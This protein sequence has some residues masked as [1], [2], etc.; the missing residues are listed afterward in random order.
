LSQF[1]PEAIEKAKS[2]KSIKIGAYSCARGVDSV[3]NNIAKFISG[4]D[5]YQANPEDIFLTYGGIDAYHH[6]LGSIFNKG[7][8][9][10]LDLF[11]I[12]FLNACLNRLVF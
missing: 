7:D 1:I 10:N 5:K 8:E 11:K 4:R 3:R 9:V 2:Y 6:I 12:L